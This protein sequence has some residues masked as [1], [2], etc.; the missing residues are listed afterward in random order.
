MAPALRR[1]AAVDAG[2]AVPAPRGLLAAL[3][4]V[5]AA[6]GARGDR[7]ARWCS[8]NLDVAAAMVTVMDEYSAVPR[9]AVLKVRWGGAHAVTG[10][11]CVELKPKSGARSPPR[12]PGVACR[13]CSQQWQKTA[14]GGAARVSGYCPSDLY[15]GAAPRVRR[16]LRALVADPQNNLRVLCR[17]RPV[18][19]RAGAAARAAGGS[20]DP[21]G[22]ALAGAAG[23]GAF[24]DA[25]ALLAALEAVMMA[26]APLLAA[27]RGLQEAAGDAT[28]ADALAAY[29]AL[30]GDV[31]AA[32]ATG[33]AAH[34]VCAPAAVVVGAAPSCNGEPHAGCPHAAARLPRGADGEGREPDG[35]D[36]RA[37]CGGGGRRRCGGGLWR[38]DF[39]RGGGAPL[40]VRCR[41]RRAPARRVF[42]RGR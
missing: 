18:F 8:T 33:G 12:P 42:D 6:G 1:W 34:R 9:G 28:P 10:E 39:G 31:L 32:L 17:G 13:Y 23:V 2:M 25:R 4:A 29:D 24:R 30:G 27:L 16:A 14:S 7:E 35:C 5:A 37:G 19:D 3:G 38:R 20:R 26:A 21:L 22:D 11:A 15:S 40:G 41:G 36:E